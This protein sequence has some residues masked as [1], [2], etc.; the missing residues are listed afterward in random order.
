[1][2]HHKQKMSAALLS[3][4]SN[5]VLVG[6][7]LAIGLV[8][9]SVSILS[10]AVHSSIDL[11]AAV[12]AWFSVREAGKPADEKHPYGHGKIENVSGTIEALLIFGA[13][14]YIIWAAVRKLISGSVGMEELGLGAAV[15]GASALV[16]Y[17]VSRHLL[18]VAIKSDSIAL[19][20]DAMHLR[21][22]VYTS[23]GVLA[24]LGVIKITGL[25]ILDPLVAIGV[26]LLIIKAAYDLTKNAFSPILDVKLPD[27]EEAIIHEVLAEHA[28]EFLEFHKLRTRKA[29]H[30]RHIDLHLVVPKDMRV[31]TA[32]V[33]S[34]TIT[35]GISSRLA[36][37]NI[38]VHI[39]PC[40]RVCAG[41]AVNCA[42]KDQW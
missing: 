39:D 20:A 5:T 24:G 12:L 10:E 25:T 41:C 29:G 8:S 22:D 16:N 6:A 42:K 31:E 23:L 21:T 13:A 19:K 1:V 11:V 9:G 17:L 2:D 35:V 36:N 15:M 4:A 28:T 26:A 38:L 14:I 7:K 30:V 32:H 18:K 40:L 3:V 33:L 37:S 34:H 27:D